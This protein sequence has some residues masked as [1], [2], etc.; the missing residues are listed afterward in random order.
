[1]GNKGL[2]GLRRLVEKDSQRFLK[3]GQRF[4][5]SGRLNRKK[6]NALSLLDRLR[7]L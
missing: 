2:G 5:E 6:F 3:I 4:S 7:V 1:M